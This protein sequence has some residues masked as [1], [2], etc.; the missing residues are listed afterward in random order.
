MPS[1]T[2]TTFTVKTEPLILALE[3]LYNN[4]GCEECKNDKCK[5]KQSTINDCDVWRNTIKQDL[6]RLELIEALYNKSLKEMET[7]KN[8]DRELYLKFKQLENE[9]INVFSNKDFDDEEKSAGLDF[10]DMIS[11]DEDITLNKNCQLIFSS[12]YFY[13]TI[14]SIS[15][16]SAAIKYVSGISPTIKLSLT[17]TSEFS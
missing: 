10:E 17:R 14:F 12:L 4:L 13:P 7:I 9:N 16:F 8:D 5:Y 6:E 1:L 2:I 15:P 11:I 3:E